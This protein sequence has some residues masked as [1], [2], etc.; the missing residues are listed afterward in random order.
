MKT[1]ANYGA[2]CV[3]CLQGCIDVRRCDGKC[4]FCLNMDCEN[5]SQKTVANQN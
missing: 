1:C 2:N 4:G 3:A 5:H